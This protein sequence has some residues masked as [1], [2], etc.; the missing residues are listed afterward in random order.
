MW[1]AITKD[2]GEFV[3]TVATDATDTLQTIDQQLDEP[4]VKKRGGGGGNNTDDGEDSEHQHRE[5]MIDPDTGISMDHV[6]VDDD[7]DDDED[8]DELIVVEVD[9]WKSPDE[10]PTVEEMRDRLISSCEDVFRDELTRPATTV[11][12]VVTADDNDDDGSSNNDLLVLEGEETSAEKGERIVAEAAAIT[13]AATESSN[14]NNNA[15]ADADADADAETEVEKFL[16]EFDVASKTDVITQLLE[17]NG[18]LKAMF[19]KLATASDE[20][21]EHVVVVTYAEFWTR[22]FYRI[23]GDETRLV[24]TYRI[25][26]NKN[27]VLQLQQQQQQQ[28]QQQQQQQQQAT[29][30]TNM[31]GLSAGVSS[32]FG[33]VVDRLTTE[34]DHNNDGD[35]QHTN[36]ANSY[37]DESMDPQG[38]TRAGSSYERTDFPDVSVGP[39]TRSALNFLSKVTNAVGNGGRPPFVMNTAV[40][41]TD[42]EDYEDDGNGR[43]GESDDGGESEEELGW[44]DDDDD[45]DVEDDDAADNKDD[46]NNGNGNDDEGETTVEFKDAEKETLLDELE[47]ARAERD[48]LQ[49]TVEMQT[50]ELKSIMAASTAPTPVVVDGELLGGNTADSDPGTTQRLQMQLFEKDSELAALRARLEDENHDDDNNNNKAAATATQQQQE[51]EISKLNILLV[52]KDN[53]LNGLRTGIAQQRKEQHNNPNNDDSNH[54]QEEALQLVTSL[55]AAKVILLEE[56]E[57]EIDLLRSQVESANSKL[58]KI[59][60]DQLQTTTEKEELHLL[61]QSEIDA[62]QQEI[63][64]HASAQQQQQQVQ[65]HDGNGNDDTENN[66]ELLRTLQIVADKDQEINALQTKLQELEIQSKEKASNEQEQ[67]EELLQQF[68]SQIKSLQEDITILQDNAEQQDQYHQEQKQ[69]STTIQEGFRSERDSARTEHKELQSKVDANKHTIVALEQEV[70]RCQL[71]ETEARNE[72]AAAKAAAEAAIAKAAA[73]TAA[74]LSSPPSPGSSNSTGV[75]VHAPGNSSSDDAAIPF[76]TTTPLPE[77]ATTTTTNNNAADLLGIDLSENN[78]DDNGDDDGWGDGW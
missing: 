12:K 34:S 62:L 35:R 46:T 8:E 23:G 59:C 22:Y 32:F 19:S 17:E 57:T 70:K 74:S 38:N 56:K 14:S 64:Q 75:Q 54:N 11:T 43:S 6:D 68:Q 33:G 13:A 51:E 20:H 55:H 61:M 76:A 47:Q 39:T 63:V 49:K 2:F 41:D 1:G 7:D 78:D 53:E 48:S 28:L 45:Y 30:S 42:D 29:L 65:V 58:Q 15:D 52:A 4:L 9:H 72:A 3:S 40:S 5:S 60:D 26:F 24:E 37:V 77:V 71:S 21:E 44:D 10:D 69:Q 25:Y 73:A 27:Y 67:D 36:D 31:S 18:K 50:E 16:R 66:K